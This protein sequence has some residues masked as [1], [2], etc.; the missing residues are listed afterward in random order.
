MSCIAYPIWISAKSAC[1]NRLASVKGF[2][3][4]ATGD[5][6]NINTSAAEHDVCVLAAMTPCAPPPST[7]S[8]VPL[9]ATPPPQ[10]PPPVAGGFSR[11]G[12]IALLAAGGVALYLYKKGKSPS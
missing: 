9:V 2:G 1:A 3:Y 11:L 8:Q 12:L 5:S 7:T 4:V 6:A 10:P